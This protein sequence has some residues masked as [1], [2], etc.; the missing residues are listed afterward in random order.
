[1]D[2]TFGVE[3][4]GPAFAK[5]HNFLQAGNCRI[6][7]IKLGAKKS[8]G[9]HPGRDS[10]FLATLVSTTFSRSLPTSYGNW[11]NLNHLFLSE[12]WV[13]CYGTAMARLRSKTHTAA[14]VLAAVW[15]LLSWCFK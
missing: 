3:T 4:F 9:F 7:Y 5:S 12:G 6:F 8:G 2:L 14:N 10:K 11:F 13:L 1:M 15:V